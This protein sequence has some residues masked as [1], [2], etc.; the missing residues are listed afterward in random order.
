MGKEQSQTKIYTK[1]Q[2]THTQNIYNDLEKI[3]TALKN[4]YYQDSTLRK[5]IQMDLLEK[6]LFSLRTDAFQSTPSR[7]EKALEIS[8]LKGFFAGL[9]RLLG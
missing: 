5:H 6:L 2:L 8:G 1:L 9:F 3:Y 7:T 4:V